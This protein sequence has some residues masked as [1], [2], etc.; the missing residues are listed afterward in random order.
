M[1]I[2]KSEK[3]RDLQVEFLLDVLQNLDARVSKTSSSLW[4]PIIINLEL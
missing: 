1:L 4:T 2:F 3:H